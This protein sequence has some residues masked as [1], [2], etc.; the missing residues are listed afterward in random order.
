MVT[1][2]AFFVLCF[3]FV[4]YSDAF[5]A[6]SFKFALRVNMELFNKGPTMKTPYG[7]YI[8]DENGPMYVPLILLP[9]TMYVVLRNV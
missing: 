6:P 1:A 9:T 2:I 7:G 4:S 3:T 5:R 8:E